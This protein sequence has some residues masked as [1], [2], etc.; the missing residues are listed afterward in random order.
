[1]TAGPLICPAQG[2]LPTSTSLRGITTP[3]SIWWTGEDDQ[4]PAETNALHYASLIP[5]ATEHCADPSAG[6]YV[7]V[8]DT[9]GADRVRSRL[10]S[11]AVAFF[12]ERLTA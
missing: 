6:H 2:Q 9:P 8:R 10:A 1:M 5:G 11:A 4:T 12:R 3:A 7:F